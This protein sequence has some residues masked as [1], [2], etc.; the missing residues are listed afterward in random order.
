MPVD[1]YGDARV[2][3]CC[4]RVFAQS[5]EWARMEQHHPGRGGG[6]LDDLEEGEQREKWEEATGRKLGAGRV[7]CHY[8]SFYEGGT[9]GRI[10][11]SW[12]VSYWCGPVRLETE[13]ERFVRWSG[14]VD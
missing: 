6:V 8:T 1:R 3:E 4:G 9:P 10:G 2:C 12:L 11:G 13:A 14:G 5:V 7:L